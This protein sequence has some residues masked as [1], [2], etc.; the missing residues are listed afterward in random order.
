MALNRLSRQLRGFYDSAKAAYMLES[1]FDVPPRYRSAFVHLGGSSEVQYLYRHFVASVSPGSRI[2]I[3]GVMGGRD[4]FL[5]K[6]L[7]FEVTAVDLG[8]QPDIAP[9]VLA[10]VEQPLPFDNGH[11]DVV[12]AGEVL[13]HLR[14]DVQAL[15]NIRRVL[16]DDGRLIVSLPFFNDWE[17][18]HMR[19]H[20]PRSGGRLLAMAGF[21]ILDFVER[22]AIVNPTWLNYPIHAL[23][24]ASLRLRGRTLYGATTSA[25]GRFALAL[26]RQR[27]WRPLRRRSPHYGG[28]YLCAKAVDLLDHI[29]LNRQLYTDSDARSDSLGG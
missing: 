21:T 1:G 17:E 22:P 27:F 11:F 16:R 24:S 6:N 23:S 25:Y 19:V 10:N 13:E 4:Y 14:E 26:G 2:L 5:F 18:G 20:S 29:G 8:P 7:G 12:L 15:L 3:V 9:I 28:Y